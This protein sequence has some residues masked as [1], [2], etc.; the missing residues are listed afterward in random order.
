MASEDRTR[1]RREQRGVI[2]NQ[3]SPDMM[4]RNSSAARAEELDRSASPTRS[5]VAAEPSF[6]PYAQQDPNHMSR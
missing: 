6:N 2:A 3:Q 1:E 4:R 5:S